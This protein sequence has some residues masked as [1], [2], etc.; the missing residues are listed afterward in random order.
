M[1]SQNIYVQ[2]DLKN[3]YTFRFEPKKKIIQIWNSKD[4]TT[5]IEIINLTFDS[6]FV[7]TITDHSQLQIVSQKLIG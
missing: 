1:N 6:K 7:V 4:N 3:D 5:W 2:N